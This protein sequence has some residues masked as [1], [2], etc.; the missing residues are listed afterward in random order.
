MAMG[1]AAGVAGMPIPFVELGIAASAIVLGLMVSLAARPPLLVAGLLV[2]VFAVFHGH[3]HGTELPVATDPLAYSAGFVIATGLLHLA[4]IGFGTL[5]RWPVGR[6]AV[7][8]AG[9]AIAV[10]GAAFVIGL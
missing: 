3:A 1:G 6:A 2:G 9:G 8:A 5:A 7:R 4:G 10:A